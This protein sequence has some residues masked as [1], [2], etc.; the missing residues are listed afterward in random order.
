MAKKKNNFSKFGN[1]Q[2]RI[3]MQKAKV[4]KKKS[5]VNSLRSSVKRMFQEACNVPVVCPHLIKVDDG[6]WTFNQNYNNNVAINFMKRFSE[7]IIPYIKSGKMTT[8]VEHE[9]SVALR[10]SGHKHPGDALTWNRFEARD[11]T[12]TLAIEG[13]W[14]AMKGSEFNKAY[15]D[16]PMTFG[17][18]DVIVCDVCPEGAK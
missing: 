17:A 6:V 14:W 2:K 11:I 10:K 5:S 4:R 1:P 15:K 7:D 18:D 3:A 16:I 9:C 12:S 8:A 13:R